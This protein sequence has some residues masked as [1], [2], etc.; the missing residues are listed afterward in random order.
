M[1]KELTSES[2]W[3][4]Y[5]KNKPK[6]DGSIIEKN[7]LFHDV[8]ETYVPRKQDIS[9]LE[10]GGY[11]GMWAIYFA[12]FWSAKSSLLDRYVD[13]DVIRALSDTNGVENIDVIEGI[14]KYGIDQTA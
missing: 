11:P 10:I 8:L 12:K 9:F 6:I 5:W 13:R 2:Y 14:G 3:S 7:F 1:N 4:R